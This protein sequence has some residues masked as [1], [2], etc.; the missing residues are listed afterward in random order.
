MSGLGWTTQYYD[1]V[2]YYFWGPDKLNA[3]R[4]PGGSVGVDVVLE[5]LRRLEEPLNHILTLFFD[6]APNAFR[7]ELVQRCAGLDLG[8][9]SEIADRSTHGMFNGLNV[10]QPD[11]LVSG[12]RGLVAIE[13]KLGSPSDLNQILKYALLLSK[14]SSGRPFGLTYL[15]QR[16]FQRHWRGLSTPTEVSAA[17]AEHLA[18]LDKLGQLRL[19]QDLRDEIAQALRVMRLTTWR[20]SDL[21]DLLSEWAN[22]LGEGPGDETLRRLCDGVSRELRARGLDAL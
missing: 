3:I 18:S 5:R 10:A 6:L 7:R 9:Y 17:A 4:K 20:F 22:R 12:D 19:T 2:E 16:P 15:T 1:A 13:V 8:G 21:N 11:V 14:S